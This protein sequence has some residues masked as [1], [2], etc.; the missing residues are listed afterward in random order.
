MRKLSLLLPVL[1]VLLA[2]SAD[3]IPP[4]P[5]VVVGVLTEQH[6]RRCRTG[7]RVDWIDPHFEVGFVHI[8]PVGGLSLAPY[9]GQPMLVWGATSRAY[10]PPAVK[11]EGVCPMAQM[12]SDWVE[13]KSGFRVRRNTL[14]F[15]AISSGY[16]QRLTGFAVTATKDT[17]TVTFTN[18][19]TRALK[20]VTL[21]MHYEGCYG[22]PGTRAKDQTFATVAPGKAV[23]ASFPKLVGPDGGGP[24]GVRGRGGRPGDHA[25]Y[26]VSV[27]GSAPLVTFDFDWRLTTDPKLAVRCP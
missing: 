27:N 22:K 11:H 20:D 23:K 17:L 12:R 24:T 10:Q 9:V 8:L 15:Q 5:E 2:S 19:F 14:P 3:A 6:A 1:A 21:R 26:S 4:P 18:P 13:A 7:G 25:A 16:V